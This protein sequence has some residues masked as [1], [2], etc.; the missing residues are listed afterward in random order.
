MVAIGPGE[1]AVLA[2]PLAAVAIEHLGPQIAVIARRIARRRRED[3]IE[4]GAAIAGRHQIDLESQFLQTAPFEI[5]DLFRSVDRGGLRRGQ[6][7]PLH[8]EQR[9]FDD[10]AEVIAL[11]ELGRGFDLGDQFRRDRLTRFVVDG[12]IAQH[13]GPGRP[14]FVNLAGILDEI[15]RRGCARQAFVT[16]V[17]E[18]PVQRVAELV[19]G[20]VDPVEADELRFPGRRLGNVQHVVDDRLRPPQVGLVDEVRHP[21]APTLGIALEGV[22]IEQAEFRTVPIEDGIGPHVR[23]IDRQ[24][25]AALE[26]EAIQLLGHEEDAVFQHLVELEIL[27]HRVFIEIVAFRLDAVGITIPVPRLD[28]VVSAIGAD[29][30]VQHGGFAP[31]RVGEG[32]DHLVHEIERRLRR[33]GHAIPHGVGRPVRL[34]EQGSL[35]RAERGNLRQQHPGVDLHPA[36]RAMHARHEQLL[37]RGAVFH[38]GKGRLLR[39]V[40]KGDGIFAVEALFLREIGGRLDVALGQAGEVFPTIEHHRLVGHGRAGLLAELGGQRGQAT[41]DRLHLLDL[42]RGQQGTGLDHA[43]IGVFEQLRVLDRHAHRRAIVVNGLHALEQRGVQRDRVVMGGQLG[44]DLGVDGVQ[45]IGRVRAGQRVEH[46]LHAVEHPP[47]LFQG[48]DGILERRSRRIVD[49]RPNLGLL[50]RH[51]LFEGR[52]IILFRNFREIGRAERQGAVR[53]EIA[54]AF[55]NCHGAF[56]LRIGHGR[57]EIVVRGTAS[58]KQRGGG[59][60]GKDLGLQQRCSPV[61]IRCRYSGPFYQALLEPRLSRESKPSKQVLIK[62]WKVRRPHPPGRRYGPPPRLRS[63][64]GG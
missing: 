46:V 22:E 38:R 28:I 53:S 60:S 10:F 40:L 56:D 61:G 12:V 45:P 5:V 11:V 4:I 1:T 14:H 32:G 6:R 35:L 42:C 48:D 52:D 44:A 9:G 25:G 8:I 27:H 36:V 59:G 26:S 41:V 49:D 54:G 37:A 13:F 16:L 58:G 51:A 18:E 3:V 62:G 15:A 7:G 63:K 55:R 50:D 34:A 19:E 17:G 47:A 20:G 57:F 21:R 24:I 31:L 33:F 39:G 64:P 30:L 23:M 2:E 29:R 43:F